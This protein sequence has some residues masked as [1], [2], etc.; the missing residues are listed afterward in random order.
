MSFIPQA[1][2]TSEIDTKRFRA[3]TGMSFFYTLYSLVVFLFFYFFFKFDISKHDIRCYE[4]VFPFVQKNSFSR[5]RKAGINN[6]W[7]THN[8]VKMQYFSL[9]DTHLHYDPI[10]FLGLRLDRTR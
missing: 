9:C 2:G 5:S 8:A 3:I 4:P 1:S 7:F 10:S 6:N